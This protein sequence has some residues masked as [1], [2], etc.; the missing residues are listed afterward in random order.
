MHRHPVH[1]WDAHTEHLVA[2]AE[3]G[4]YFVL[5]IAHWGLMRI[6]C[7]TAQY[8][9]HLVPCRTRSTKSVP[10]RYTASTLEPLMALGAAL[11][12]DSSLVVC[13]RQRL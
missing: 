8:T 7:T 6:C 1:M 12:C 10:H 13:R 11:K 5:C 3:K 2:S 4:R 9:G